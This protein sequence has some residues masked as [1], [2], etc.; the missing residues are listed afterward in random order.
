MSNYYRTILNAQGS[1]FTNTKSIAL[2]GVDDF[3]AISANSNLQISDT[4]TI[5]QWIK[6]TSTSQ[7]YVTNFANKFGVYVQNGSVYL[8]FRNLS[9]SQ[10][11]LQSASTINDGNYHNVTVVKT[12]STMAIYIDGTLNASNTNGATGI[13]SALS[14]AIG[15]LFNGSIP[16]SGTIDEV[17]IW[18][19]DQSANAN[20][21]GG[22]IPTD[23]SAY[24][25]LSWWRCGDGDTSP[26]LTDNGSG[27]NNGTMTNFSTFSTDVPT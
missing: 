3:V 23:L 12:S 15:S 5:S 18:N 21:I 20:V 11:T 8:V 19:S 2:D 1:S 9:N 14:N 7:M 17:A 22:T 4:F 13:T 6:F 10:I 16:F 26:T 27:G 24:N 25:P